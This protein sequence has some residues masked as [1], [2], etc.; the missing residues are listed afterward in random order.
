METSHGTW[1]ERVITFKWD[2]GIS[3]ILFLEPNKRCSYHHHN[4]NWNQFFCIK[5]KLGVKTDKGHITHL[6]ER[7]CFTVEP[8]VKHEFMTYNEPTIIEEIAFV[9]YEPLDI[10]REMPGGDIPDLLNTYV[11]PKGEV[12]TPPE[13][14]T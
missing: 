9:K 13:V 1:G 4:Q 2:G 10:H 7:Q 6:T 3:T 8:G 5:G 11:S 14:K 12:I